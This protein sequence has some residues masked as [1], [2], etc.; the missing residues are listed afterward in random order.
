MTKTTSACPYCGEP[1]DNARRVQCG[2]SECKRQYVNERQRDFQRKH[3][4]ETGERYSNRYVPKPRQHAITCE[5]CG[6]EAVVTK[7][8]ARHCSH[9]CWYDAKHAA[10]SQVQ[11]W[12]PLPMAPS[13]TQAMEPQ[14]LRR[15]W[16]SSRCPMCMVWFLT[17]NPRYQHCSPKCGRRG[18]KDKRRALERQAFVAPVSRIQVYERDRWTCQL[19]GKPVMRGKVVP[20]PKAPTLDHVIPLSRGG[21]HEPAN[22]Q[23]AHYWCNTIKSDGSWGRGEQLALIG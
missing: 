7:T 10:H 8:D 19:C 14:R 9:R 5:Q 4:S 15:C 23:L 1:M 6:K 3:R 18:A 2:A 13:T 17:D 21:T 12:Q 22:V 20:H 16:Y 11:L